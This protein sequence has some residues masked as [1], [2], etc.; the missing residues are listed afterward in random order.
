MQRV[1]GSTTGKKSI[2]DSFIGPCQPIKATYFTHFTYLAFF[3][4]LLATETSHQFCHSHQSGEKQLLT[5][6]SL[7]TSTAKL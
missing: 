2:K 7:M 1:S 3:T 4:T 6:C 5:Q